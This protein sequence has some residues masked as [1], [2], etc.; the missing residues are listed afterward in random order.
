MKTIKE[1]LI[2]AIFIS[3]IGCSAKNHDDYV[4][5]YQYKNTF[6]GETD[7]IQ[8][9]KEN[10]TYFLIDGNQPF[11]AE[12]NDNLLKVNGQTLALSKDKQE[13][14]FGGTTAKRMSDADAVAYLDRVKMEKE[15]CKKLDEEAK[16]KSS[17]IK[18]KDEWNQYVDNLQAR[19]PQNCRLMNDGKRF[20]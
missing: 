20:L 11:P 17:V 13:L 9:K 7:I 18:N 6:S 10:D 4:G 12:A 2:A 5:Y 15:A 16:Q 1:I 19:K 14:I 8:I 3:I